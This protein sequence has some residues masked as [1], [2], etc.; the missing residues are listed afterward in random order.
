MSNENKAITNFEEKGI[1]SI[2][3]SKLSPK[4]K[5]VW[6]RIDGD[7]R[8]NTEGRWGGRDAANFYYSLDGENWTKI[9][10]T[11]FKMRFDWRRFFMGSKYAIFNYATKKSG[12][13]IDVDE[14]KKLTPQ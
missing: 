7:F 12:G 1:E 8:A 11:D 3:L 14:F 6:L 5:K 10:T 2:S 13:Y 9:G 4:S